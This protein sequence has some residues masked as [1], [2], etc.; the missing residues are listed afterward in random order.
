M[1]RR[2][3]P[4]ETPPDSSIKE[5]PTGVVMSC[6]FCPFQLHGG[7]IITATIAEKWYLKMAR[8]IRDEHISR[9]RR[10]PLRDDLKEKIDAE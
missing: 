5:V 2:A 1:P 8:H 7:K 6:P 9:G 10:V 4:L 3:E